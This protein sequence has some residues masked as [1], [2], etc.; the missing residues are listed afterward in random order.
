MQLRLCLDEIDGVSFA[1]RVYTLTHEEPI[2]FSTFNQF[3]TRVDEYLDILGR[4][5]SF[6]EKRSMKD[7]RIKLHGYHYRINTIKEPDEL[8]IFHG[9]KNT[10]DLY[11]NT[12][13]NTE[14]QGEICNQQNSCLLFDTVL[15]LMDIICKDKI[16]ET[17]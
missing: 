3:T 14:W 15:G 10:F 12:R 6:Q 11:I 17:F 8:T 2:C 13:K 9:Q 16:N 5:Q 4:P 1:G 7:D